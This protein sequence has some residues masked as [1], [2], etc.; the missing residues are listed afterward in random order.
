VTA[1]ASARAK[2][3]LIVDEDPAV[4]VSLARDLGLSFEP[5]AAQDADEALRILEREP[6]IVAV[7]CHVNISRGRRGG[8]E[9]MADIARLRPGMARI[10]YSQ[11]TTDDADA[12]A[13]AFVARPWKPGEMLRTL[14]RTL[15]RL[16][17]TRPPG[18]RKAS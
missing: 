16:H 5:I 12:F 1:A 6:E 17:P 14:V 18:Y 3:V 13:H 8:P 7:I 4:L 9:L 10:F 11:C 2:K 15:R